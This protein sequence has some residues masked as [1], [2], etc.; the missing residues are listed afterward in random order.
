ML[1]RAA[2][3]LQREVEVRASFL[4]RRMAD[5]D[6]SWVLLRFGHVRHDLE[7]GA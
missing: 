3:R 7:V 6:G 2:E 4:A 5:E 1:E